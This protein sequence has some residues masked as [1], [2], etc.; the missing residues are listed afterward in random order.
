MGKRRK[1]LLLCVLI[2]TLSGCAPR[3]ETPLRV[4]T[5]VDVACDRGYQIWRRQYKSPEKIK[6]V[7]NYLRLQDSLGAVETDPERLTGDALQIKVWLSDGTSRIYYQK[8]EQ[9]LSKQLHAW[10]TIDPKRAAQFSDYLRRTP[11]DL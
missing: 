2:L 7:L 5:Q 8:S 10:Q 1:I 4:V 6:E 3:E 11:T 9:Y